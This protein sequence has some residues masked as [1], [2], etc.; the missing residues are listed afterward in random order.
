[1]LKLTGILIFLSVLLF[2]ADGKIL[3]KLGIT[4]DQNTQI[5]K[6]MTEYRVPI[7]KLVIQIRQEQL[8]KQYELLA[9]EP[10]LDKI[11]AMINKQVAL[12]SEK[13]YLE[14][15]R[16]QKIRKQL[17]KDQWMKFL[18]YRHMLKGQSEKNRKK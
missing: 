1:M 7:L 10:G 2:P 11:K 3:E 12:E 5:E 8:A 17:T 15:E 18:Q 4:P 16:D 9:D 6:I 14:I 13:E